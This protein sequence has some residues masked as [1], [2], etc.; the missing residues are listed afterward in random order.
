MRCFLREIVARGEIVMTTAE[1]LAELVELMN[2]HGPNSP[3]IIG[4]I[5]D[6]EKENPEFAQLAKVALN[7]K[8]GLLLLEDYTD[9]E[10]D[11][12]D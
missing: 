12:D 1:L 10:D 2:L 8:K 7:L 4:F 5:F 9:N 6:H 3:K 11:E